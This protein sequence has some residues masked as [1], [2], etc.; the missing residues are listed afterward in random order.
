MTSTSEAKSSDF[1]N[2]IVLSKFLIEIA[3]IL[4]VHK[5]LNQRFPLVERRKFREQESRSRTVRYVAENRQ[6]TTVL[7]RKVAHG[8]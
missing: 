4:D 3:K 5:L 6:I 1:F 2:F 7:G 8:T